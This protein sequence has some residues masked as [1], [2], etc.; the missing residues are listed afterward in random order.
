VTVEVVPDSYDAVVRELN[1]GEREE[2]FPVLVA[3]YT[4]FG[5]YQARI[6]RVIPMFE[7]VPV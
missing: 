2:L 1:S 5:D 6:E 7:L 4:F 3:R